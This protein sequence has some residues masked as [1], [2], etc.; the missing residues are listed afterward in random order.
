MQ[1][2]STK[3]LN[4][5]PEHLPLA[6]QGLKHFLRDLEYG[7]LSIH[8][9]HAQSLHLRGRHDGPHAHWHLHQP[10]QLLQRVL[11]GGIIGFAEGFHEGDWSSPDVAKLLHLGALNM[12][13][14]EAQLRPN[15]FLRQLH[16]LQHLRRPNSKRGSRKNIAAHYDLGNDFYRLWLDETMSYSSALFTQPELS[17]A[18]A[19]EEKYARLLGL[20]DAKP[21]QHIL[22]I[23]C[24]WGGFAEHAAQRGL[25][26]TG[27]TLSSEQLKWSKQRLMDAGLADKAQFSLMDYR[28]Q[29]G[30]FDHIVSIEMFE[31][32]GEKY[33][34]SYFQSVY[35]RLKPGGRAAIQ[36]IVIAEKDYPRYRCEPDYIQLYIFP[37]GMLPTQNL[38]VQGAEAAGLRVREQALFG[39]DYAQTLAHWRATFEAK[40]AE[41]SELGYDSRFC[42]MWS[43][44]LAYCEAAFRAKRCDLLQIVLEKPL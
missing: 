27:I 1:V 11:R 34:P 19:Q 4:F 40:N 30:E 2:E 3:T 26:T 10:A 28:D 36:V 25:Q 15:W 32:V 29:S 22:E 14:M 42:R 21:S 6:A 44:Y 24:G 31:A 41:I 20:L 37:G 13:A 39:L 38:F 9:D 5:S 33:W 43:Y 35:Q 12:D 18:R 8:F 17:L 7:Y 23:G 16:R